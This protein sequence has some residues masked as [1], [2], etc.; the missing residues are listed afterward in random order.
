MKRSVVIILIGVLFSSLA[1]CGTGYKSKPVPFKAPTAYPNATEAAG[2]IVAAKAFVDSGEANEAFGFDIRGAGMLPVQVVF[3]N[4]GSHFLEINAAQTFL[5]DTEGNLW[6]ILPREAAYERATKYAQTKRIFKEGA[7]SGFLGAAAGTV[8]GAAIGVVAGNNVAQAAG[9]GAAAG[10]AAGATLG[11]AKAY[12]SN[13]ARRAIINDL[14]QKSLQTKAI[15]PKSLAYGFLFFPG[16]AESAKQLRLQ[17]LEEDTGYAHV[18]L[19]NF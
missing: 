18:L 10:A 6:P 3:D 15:E 19:L 9:K 11:G 13:D 12:G 1:A 14:R 17:V 4:R 8:I 16:E 5:E 7:Y 2:A